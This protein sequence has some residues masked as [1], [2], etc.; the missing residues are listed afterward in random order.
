MNCRFNLFIKFPLNCSFNCTTKY[1]W[2][3]T[4]LSFF[5]KS[6][7]GSE[8][9][10]NGKKQHQKR[11]SNKK[12]THSRNKKEKKVMSFYVSNACIFHQTI[13]RSKTLRRYF[14]RRLRFGCYRRRR[15][16]R[17]HS[18][19]GY[20]GSIQNVMLK[21]KKQIEHQRYKSQSELCK[22]AK[23]FSKIVC[24]EKYI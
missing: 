12:D 9:N 17:M 24:T 15:L 7:K 23:Y 8:L 11:R 4:V 20:V 2:L 5:H 3:I 13:N 10:N 6:P 1:I 22:I 21:H 19:V 14:H 16:F 18:V